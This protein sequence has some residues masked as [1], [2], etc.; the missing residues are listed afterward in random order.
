M[1]NVKT[2]TLTVSTTQNV[3]LVLETIK[4]VKRKE[5]VTGELQLHSG[6]G[7]QYSK[8]NVFIG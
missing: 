3:Q 8:Q 6:Q 2:I 7:F 1:P 4:T 5:K